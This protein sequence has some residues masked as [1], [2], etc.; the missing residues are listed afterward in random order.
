MHHDTPLA[1]N[2]CEAAARGDCVSVRALL[3]EG[4]DV[5]G[6]R[7]AARAPLH[8]AALH[9]HAEALQLLLGA[10]ADVLRADGTGHTALQLAALYGCERSVRLLVQGGADVHAKV[11]HLGE[12]RGALELAS[13]A[14]P[15]LRLRGSLGHFFARAP[16]LFGALSFVL[17]AQCVWHNTALLCPICLGNVPLA[18]WAHA[19][20]RT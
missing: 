18:V 3:L 10:G 9:G 14:P 17:C 15:P 20:R 16:P 19:P 11:T 6:G 1:R 7:A 12:Q 4:A 5:D 8:H 2:R 13:R